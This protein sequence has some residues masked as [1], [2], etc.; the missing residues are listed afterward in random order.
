MEEMR[1]DIIAK[2]E[3]AIGKE[4]KSYQTPGVPGQTLKKNEGVPVMMPEYISILGQALYYSTKLGPTM[5]N[6]VRELASHMS[7]PGDEH[8]KALGRTVGYL[9]A[10]GRYQY[11]FELRAPEDLRGILFL[12]GGPSVPAPLELTLAISSCSCF[13]SRSSRRACVTLG[14]MSLSISNTSSPSELKNLPPYYWITSTILTRANSPFSFE[15]NL[16]YN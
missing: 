9:K 8:W 7:N 2:F 11:Q 13:L 12:L 5:A 15:V 3:K 1:L 14:K 16:A 10:R 6:S 4:V